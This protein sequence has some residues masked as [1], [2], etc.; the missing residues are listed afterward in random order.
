MANL[1]ALDLAW[2]Y[3]LENKSAEALLM[4]GKKTKEVEQN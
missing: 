1:S 3:E 4:L 2:V